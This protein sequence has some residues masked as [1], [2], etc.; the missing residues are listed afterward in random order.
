MKLT[1]LFFYLAIGALCH[2]AFVGSHFDWNSAW[3]FAWLLGWP[4]MLG[5]WA[6]AIGVVVLIAVWCLS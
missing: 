3:T 4:I 5:F 1:G 6:F 2:L